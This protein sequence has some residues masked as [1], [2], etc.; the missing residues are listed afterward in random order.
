LKIIEITAREILDSRGNPT[1]AASCILRDGSF[2]EVGVPSG[3]STGEK[4]A[5]ELR[6]KDSRRFQGLGVLSAV[7]SVNEKIAPAI[8]GLDAKNQTLIDRTLCELDGSDNKENLGANAIL[9]VSL[10]VAKAQAISDELELFEYLKV[11]YNKIHGGKYKLPTPMFNVLNGGKHAENNIDIQ[12]TMIVPVGPKTFFKKLQAGSEIYHTL[13]NNLLSEGY[14]VGLGDE[15]GFAP[16]FKNNEEVFKAVSKAIADAGYKESSIRIS[17]DVAADSLYNKKTKTYQLLGES[18]DLDSR[19]MIILLQKWNKKYNF[20]SIEDGLFENDSK[21][22]EL[23]A[24]IKPTFSVGDDL[25]VTNSQKIGLA[26]KN[27]LANGVIIKPNQVGTLTETL[28]AIKVAQSNRFKIIISHRSGETTDSF[29]ADL[30]V[31]VGAD[32]IKAGAP[33]RSERLS[34]YNRLAKIEEVLNK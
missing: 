34:K 27:N 9:A 28:K 31:A 20:L 22:P 10:A 1:V 15:G 3:A 23:T 6:D 32:Y 2:A 7:N 5:V 13:K 33:A 12:E 11:K 19:R 8:T 21:W 24:T 29:I 30:A 16:D 4:E 14:F 25:L 18:K 17:L 26:A